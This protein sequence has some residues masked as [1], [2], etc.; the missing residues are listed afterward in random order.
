MD[1]GG[2]GVEVGGERTGGRVGGVFKSDSDPTA[3]NNWS[4]FFFKASRSSI[5]AKSCALA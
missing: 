5:S 1:T 3:F 2:V 4:R